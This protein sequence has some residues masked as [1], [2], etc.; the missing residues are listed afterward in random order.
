[1]PWL[2]VLSVSCK[3]QIFVDNFLSSWGT[4]FGCFVLF[5]SITHHRAIRIPY[6]VVVNNVSLYFLSYIALAVNRIRPSH[7][8]R[9]PPF[10]GKNPNNSLSVG[11]KSSHLLIRPDKLYSIGN[12]SWKS[13]KKENK[14]KSMSLRKRSTSICFTWPNSIT[15]ESQYKE[16]PTDWRNLF[17]LTR[18]FFLQF[19]ITR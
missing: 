9:K 17:A 14:R 3:D 11:W 12:S 8:T 13:N 1:M 2:Y 16:G 4:A 6:W 7:L 19:N 5:F 10:R 18:F 15:V